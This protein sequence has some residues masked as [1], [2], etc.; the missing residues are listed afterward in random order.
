MSQGMN[1][2]ARKALLED[3]RLEEAITV[4]QRA[5]ID[6]V[7]GLGSVGRSGSDRTDS[8]ALFSRV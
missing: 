7:R 3:G 5:L 8:R 1:E 4:N 2:L 6:K